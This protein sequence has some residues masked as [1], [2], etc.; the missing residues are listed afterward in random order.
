MDMVA[1]AY[2]P[3]TEL[4][5][6]TNDG[7]ENAVTDAMS[8]AGKRLACLSNDMVEYNGDFDGPMGSSDHVPFQRAGIASSLF[9]NVDPA[10]KDVPRSAIEPY[11]HK[12]EDVMAHVSSDRLERTIKLVGLAVYDT[13]NVK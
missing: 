12:P 11:Y 1:T 4:A 5:V 13:L 7:E 8:L 3:C 6:Y 2:A 10:K 9:I